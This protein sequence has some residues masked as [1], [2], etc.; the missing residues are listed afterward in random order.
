MTITPSMQ[1]DRYKIHDIEIVIDRL[2]V[3]KVS[4]QRLQDTIKTAMKSGD[5]YFT[6]LDSNDKE[7]PYSKFLMDPE[8]GIS[9]DEPQPNMFSFNSPYGACKACE[10]LGEIGEVNMEFIIP[11][12][13]KSIN[14]GGILPLGELRENWT[15][16]QLRALAGQLK[17]SL[18]DPIEKLTDDQLNA[19]LYGYE[20][21]TPVTQT[22]SDG[23]KKSWETTYKGVV[24]IVSESY[25]ESDDDKLRQWP[26]EFILQSTCKVCHGDLLKIEA[27]S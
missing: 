6:I 16:M 27:L 1:L 25:Y 18:A 22:G 23:K 2:E 10:G 8:S 26:E 7:F 15:F 19:V 12:K 20:E 13:K 17:F 14:K 11:D 3:K 4:T 24:N 9:Y 21:P 5:G